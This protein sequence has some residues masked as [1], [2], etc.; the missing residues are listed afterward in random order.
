MANVDILKSYLVS[1]GFTVNEPEYRK[2]TDVLNKSA[3]Q[4]EG[5][6]KGMAQNF[7]RASTQIVGSL[8][9]IAAATVGLM[10]QVSRADL[11]YQEF[12]LRMHMTIPAAKE[13]K[14]VLDAMGESMENVAWIPEHRERYFTLLAQARQL[15]GSSGTGSEAFRAMRDLRFELTRLRLE[16]TYMGQYLTLSL[17]KKL[18]ETMGM[19]KMSFKEF[20]DYITNNMPQ[21]A[22]K[23][24]NKLVPVFTLLKSGW[25]VVKDIYGLFKQFWDSLGPGG[26]K[27]TIFAGILAAFFLGGPWLQ[28]KM[29]IGGLILLIDDFYAYIDGRKSAKALAPVWKEFTAVMEYIRTGNFDESIQ[30]VGTLGLVLGDA[31]RAT[32][33]LVK[34]VKDLFGIGNSGAGNGIVNIFQKLG[35]AVRLLG[36]ARIMVIRVILALVDALGQ[37]LQGNLSAA[38]QRLQQLGSDVQSFAQGQADHSPGATTTAD[39]RWSLGASGTSKSDFDAYIKEASQMYGVPESLIRKVMQ[40]ESSGNPN[41]VSSSGAIGLMQLMPGT[42]AELG[43]NP[44]DPRQNILGGTKYLAQ[45]YALEG[46]WPNALRA[47]NGGPGWRTSGAANTREN[48]EYAGRVL[49]AG[50]AGAANYSAL[51]NSAYQSLGGGNYQVQTSVGSITVNVGSTNASSQD[52]YMATLKAMQDAVNRQNARKNNEYA[53]PIT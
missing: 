14:L 15:E 36:D 6:T 19:A 37:V 7:V 1:L 32:H 39:I 46:N 8:G 23:I 20:N 43:V 44:Y 52:I 4:V 25:R 21:I 49:G 2:M 13:M 26:Q 11:K 48:Q 22:D 18:G 28:A 51:T 16:A 41:A 17:V 42:A 5:F 34:G 10:D 45:M 29:V 38:K 24:A 3:Q 9:A 31:A 12:A 47:Y 27:L 33:S 50:Y 30:N 40:A 53:S 35:D